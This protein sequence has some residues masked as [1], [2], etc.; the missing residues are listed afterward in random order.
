MD[1]SNGRED[2]IFNLIT[3]AAAVRRNFSFLDGKESI[4]VETAMKKASDSTGVSPALWRGGLKNSNGQEIYSLTYGNIEA[5]I[6]KAG[7][8]LCRLINPQPCSE[9]IYNTEDLKAEAEKF[10][11]VQ[12]YRDMIVIFS[13]EDEFTVSF[14]FAPMVN[15]VLLLT[16]HTEIDLC[17]SNRAV[18][19]FDALNYIKNYRSN[20]H[21]A[22][23]MPKTDNLIPKNLLLNETVVCVA[24]IDGNEKLC[25]LAVCSFGRDKVHIYIDYYSLKIIKTRMA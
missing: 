3:P 6:S 5:D 4:S 13:S 22:S 8:I 23:E 2:E 11:S 19:Y 12:G 21:I 20:V 7:G 15:G 1:F 14:S 9:S 18:T 24:D 25:C 10:L 16:A 17:R